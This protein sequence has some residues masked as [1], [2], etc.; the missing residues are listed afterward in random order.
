MLYLVGQC[1]V[2]GWH[3]VIVLCLEPINGQRFTQVISL[4]KLVNRQVWSSRGTRTWHIL[5]W[6]MQS[7][8][9]VVSKHEENVSV[10]TRVLW[11]SCT[12]IAH[13]V[14]TRLAHH[15]AT[16][17]TTV[18]NVGTNVVQP[19]TT[20][21]VLSGWCIRV[22]HDNSQKLFIRVRLDVYHWLVSDLSWSQW[23]KVVTK[24]TRLI[25]LDNE[26]CVVGRTSVVWPD[27]M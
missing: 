6:R 8:V 14:F 2:Q 23:I 26:L 17:T 15:T 1:L 10:Q 18:W 12:D 3:I 5:I 20:N 4:S 16:T 27:V 21:R 24:C 22:N 13:K 9:I 11:R 25:V 19:F 7:Q